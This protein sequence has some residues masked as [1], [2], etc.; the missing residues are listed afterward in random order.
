MKKTYAI[1]ICAGFLSCSGA[2]ARTTAEAV[3]SAY[4][5]LWARF[6]SPQG[7][8]YDYVGE[9]PT[10]EDCAACRPNAMGWWSP[11][12]NGPM[13]TGPFLWAMV[14]RARRTGAAEDREK[15]RR[16]VEGLILCADVCG[17]PG[18]ICRGVGSDG[19]CHYPLGSCDQTVPW[20]FGMDAYLRGGFGDAALRER[21]R[22]KMVAVA[23]AL[24]KTGWRLPCDGAFAQEFRGNLV[25]DA[26]PFRGAT[27]YLFILRALADATGE[28]KWRRAYRAAR[29]ERYPGAGKNAEPYAET[30]LEVCAYGYRYDREKSRHPFQME[31]LQFWIYVCAHQALAELAARE[32][33]PRA[34]RLYREGLVKGAKWAAPFVEDY[35]K[36]DN[37]AARPFGY[38]N[39]RRGWRWREQKTQADAAQVAKASVPEVLGTR[40]QYERRYLTSPL[41]AAAICA[42]DAAYRPAVEQALRFYDYTTP[43][44]SEFFFAAVAYEAL[45]ATW[46]RQAD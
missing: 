37:R 4:A 38:A 15:C 14:Q 29:D 33:E 26:L 25:S 13:F 17:T 46:A 22:A 31:P 18:M 45:H 8:L 41:A 1:L 42:F 35:R 44:I 43:N 19:R 28:A 16:L 32:E 11:I 12:E 23:A 40:K 36:W 5:E 24:E 39:W 9:L 34:A 20:F 21:V 6:V 7:L 3:D 27:H 10:P 30:R 2:A